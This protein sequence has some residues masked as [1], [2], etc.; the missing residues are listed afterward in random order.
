V[1]AAVRLVV[2]RALGQAPDGAH[3]A[4]GPY[5]RGARGERRTG[6]ETTRDADH[7]H[8]GMESTPAAGGVRKSLTSQKPF[9]PPIPRFAG[10]TVAPPR[11]R[12]SSP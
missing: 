1:Q 10:D 8:P 12:T 2:P 4:G 9:A 5:T 11:R 7:A 6:R 3:R